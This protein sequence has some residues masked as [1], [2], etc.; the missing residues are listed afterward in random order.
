MRKLRP[1]WALLLL[2]MSLPGTLQ[3]EDVPSLARLSFW[4]APERMAEFE[5]AYAE[6]VEPFLI[7]RGLV[8]S[9]TSS[10]ATVDSV[11]SRLFEFE[12]LAA[13]NMAVQA[14]LEP[15]LRALLQE[16]GTAFGT[17]R[18]DG[19]IP[20]NF[21][22]YHVPAGPGHTV[23]GGPGQGHWRIYDE[24][25]APVQLESMLQDQQGYLWFATRTSGAYHYDGQSWTNFA[26]QDGLASDLLT[27]IVEDREGH[28]WV[29]TAD[30]GVSR[31]DGQDWTSF[32]DADGLAGNQVRSMVVD[33]DGH[34]WF[35][36]ADKGVSRYDGKQFETFPTPH[37]LAGNAI[38]EIL[39]DRDGHLWFG[40][41]EEGVSRYDGERFT[42]FTT[43][44]GL[45]SNAINEI[46]QDREEHLWFLT[47]DGVGSYEQ[48]WTTY[49]TRDGLVHRKVVS[50]LQ[51]R[52]GHLWF[53]T[54]GSGVSRYDGQDWTSFTTEDGLA[55]NGVW[56]ILQDREGHIWFGTSRYDGNSFAKFTAEDGMGGNIAVSSL[57]DRD[58]NVWFGAGGRGSHGQNE[59]GGVSRYD[60]HGWSTF[61]T[62]DG[63]GHRHVRGIL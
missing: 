42:T 24:A 43:Q 7:E 4:L 34:L 48:T 20:Y 36:T 15:K 3:A 19:L 58:G 6:K 53:G 1:I 18:V 8:P 32:T 26:T 21:S 35:G 22:S 10:R 49:T 56:T 61:T 57:D 31:Y 40:T 25:D 52:D 30:H 51:D 23:R 16:F 2:S 46:F 38:N 60:E 17:P 45:T 37:R 62:R 29:G 9:S 59:T 14:E 12:D 55:A 5:G 47:R 54:A 50:I 33:R 41:S 27:A 28:I 11:F 39:Q 63:L 44:Q 13:L